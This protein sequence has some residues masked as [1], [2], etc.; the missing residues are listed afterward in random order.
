MTTLS[1]I[2]RHKIIAIIRGAD[3]ANVLKIAEALHE[4]GIRILEI[5]F[6]SPDALAAVKE[7]SLKMGNELVIG[8]GTVLDAATTKQ[9]IEA[10]ARFIISPTYNKETVEATKQLGAVSIPGAFTPTEILTAYI[11]GGDIIKVFP[12]ASNFNYIRDVRA[13]LPHIPLMP[14]GGIN[15][16]NILDFKKAGAVAFGIGSALV[17]TKRKITGEYLK[18]ITENA[19]RFAQA[20][21]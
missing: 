12:A 16:E 2:L 14:T 19:C 1:Q 7:L 11:N 15:L 6:N 4:G 13:P 9:A 8:M 17:D 21:S 3:P 20:V 10:G 5:T 18:K